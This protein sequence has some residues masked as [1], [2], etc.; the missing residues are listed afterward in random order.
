[1]RQ[2]RW[3]YILLAFTLLLASCQPAGVSVSIEGS[4]ALV[5][6]EP[7]DVLAA[8]VDPTPAPQE[9][10]QPVIDECLSCHADKDRLI[11]TADPVE[12]AAESESKGVG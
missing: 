2:I 12:E 8:V 1:M 9:E 3:F 6:T 4:T 11:E 5:A 7:P 10:A